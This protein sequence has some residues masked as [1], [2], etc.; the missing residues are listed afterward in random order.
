VK[1]INADE[2][3]T[4]RSRNLMRIQDV[5]WKQKGNKE[6]GQEKRFWKDRDSGLIS[7]E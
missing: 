5:S 3:N 2:G 7:F 6:T 4:K 1:E